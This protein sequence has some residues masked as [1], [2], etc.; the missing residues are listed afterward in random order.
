MPGLERLMNKANLFLILGLAGGT[1]LGL[2]SSG[3]FNSHDPKPSGHTP[4]GAPII[5][6]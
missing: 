1:V 5:C 2:V 3:T 4:A 6:N